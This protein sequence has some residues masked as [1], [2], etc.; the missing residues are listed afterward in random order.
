MLDLID[1]GF[2]TLLLMCLKAS[3]RLLPWLFD[4]PI[5]TVSTGRFEVKLYVTDKL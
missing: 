2:G 1:L 4:L 5:Q 3:L